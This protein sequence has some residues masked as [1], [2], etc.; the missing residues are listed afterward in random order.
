MSGTAR[1]LS[2][3][4]IVDTLVVVI[5]ALSVLATLAGLFWPGGEGPATITTYRGQEVDLFG[6]GIYRDSSA[7]NGAGA[8]GT[9]LTTLLIGVPML[10]IG[11]VMHR[12]GSVRGTLV[13]SGA[14]A[15]TLYA[16][17]STSLG[18]IAYHDLFLMHVAIFACSLWALV[19]LLA[20]RD[21]RG[22][23]RRPGTGMPRRGLAIFLVASGAIT[24][25]IWLVEPVVALFTG[26][27]PPSLGVSTTLF[28]T[29]F[30]IGVI[31]P[32]TWVVAALVRRGDPA[33]YLFAV[34]ILVLEAMLAPMMIAQTA[35]QLE[36]GVEFTTGQVVGIIGGFM[37]LALVATWMLRGI[38]RQIEDPVRWDLLGHR[39]E[40]R[41]AH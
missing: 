39:H 10:A 34:P 35:F 29:A 5:A 15:W 12:R 8:R 4:T 1:V 24:A 36:A 2:R 30:D 14:L 22:F 13:L 37:A 18:A 17:G 33:G 19:L 9:D 41:L 38:F 27:V 26:D 21:I 20:R 31:V 3:L 7:F 32:A 23:D 25:G 40:G 11:L 28:T 16:Y 6:R